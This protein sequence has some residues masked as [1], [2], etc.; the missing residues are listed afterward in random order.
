MWG[1]GDEAQPPRAQGE[2]KQMGTLGWQGIVWQSSDTHAWQKPELTSW[3]QGD[4]EAQPTQAQGEEEPN[5]TLGWQG[6]VWQSSD[7]HAWQKPD[8]P[9]WDRATQIPSQWKCGKSP[10]RRQIGTQSWRGSPKWHKRT[11]KAGAK[12]EVGPMVSRRGKAANVH[13]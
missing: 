10:T 4:E 2:E 3:V 12:E 9:M 13:S 5:S 1:Q 8:V 11:A 7:T 6:I